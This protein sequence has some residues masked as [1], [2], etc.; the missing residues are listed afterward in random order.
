MKRAKQKEL[1]N[2][3]FERDQ[4][5]R[6]KDLSQYFSLSERTI[7][8]YINEL[9][10][11][12]SPDNLIVKS[13]DKF[14]IDKKNYIHF[15]KEAHFLDKTPETP[16]ERRDYLLKELL[17]NEEGIDIFTMSDRL[18]VSVSS[19]ENDLNKIRR[20]IQKQNLSLQRRNEMIRLVGEEINKRKLM[21]KFYYDEHL[22]FSVIQREFKDYD[23][24]SIKK[25]LIRILENYNLFLSEYSINSVLLHII[26]SI[27]RMKEGMI[28]EIENVELLEQTLEFQAAVDISK[29]MSECLEVTFAPAEL[30]YLTLLLKSNTTILRYNEVNESNIHHFIEEDYIDLTN[31]ILERIKQYFFINMDEEEFKVKFALHLKNLIIRNKYN[32][33]SKNPMTKKIK[34]AYPLIYDLSVFIANEIKKEKGFL[35]NEDEIAYISF[36]IGAF[37]ERKKEVESKIMT[38]IIAPDYYG[39]REDLMNNLLKRFGDSIE[40]DQVLSSE[41]RD[42]DLSKTDLIITTIEPT[43]DMKI[44]FVQINLFLTEKD[45]RK[46]FNKVEELKME[47]YYNNIHMYLNQYFEEKLFEKNRYFNDELEAIEYLG[48]KLKKYQYVNDEYIQS[49]IER[50]KMSSTAFNNIVAVPHSMKMNACKTS[51][52][53]II[54]DE[55]QSWGDSHVHIIALITINEKERKDFRYIFDSFIKVLSEV[56][57]THLLIQ[58]EDYDTFIKNLSTMMKKP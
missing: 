33:Y 56:T 46:I 43:F 44:P 2:F 58:S 35:I 5:F 27:E 31:K 1:L 50:E 12:S 14:K 47:K 53:I 34:Y 19:I 23:F 24:D 10:E 6:V 30:H 18:F 40:I 37:F 26:I 17:F 16:A 41:K 48:D 21:N 3:L 32:R 13:N 7:R 42:L 36:H 49:I 25:T 15:K 8:N 51:I 57:N 39:L 4:W 45:K 22:P 55:P 38:T 28:V 20:E 54:N 29:E 52:S 9:N 11:M